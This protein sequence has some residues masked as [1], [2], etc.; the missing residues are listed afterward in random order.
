MK[1]KT[2]LIVDDEIE[3]LH[4]ITSIFTNAGYKN[5][6]IAKSAEEALTLMKQQLPS[7]VITDV[8]M[9]RMDGFELLQEI[10]AISHIPVMVLT[11]KNEAEDRFS[12]FELGADDYLAKPFLPKELLLRVGAILN[13]TYPDGNRKIQLN[14]SIV[15]F[16]QAIVIK[17][18]RKLTLTAKE[19]AVLEKLAD[20]HGHIV[21]MGALCQSVCGDIWQGY[22]STLM[23]HI[24]HLREKIEADPSNPKSLITVKGLGYKLVAEE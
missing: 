17:D 3:I 6:I 14:A 7:M 19:F 10:R 18:G 9:P 8:M 24:R 2:I 13:R 12:G 21:T 5:I 15:D 22:E 1:N 16:D 23:T 4:M 11:A 20:N